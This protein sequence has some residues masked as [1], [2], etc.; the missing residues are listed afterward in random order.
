MGVIVYPDNQVIQEPNLLTP[1]RPPVGTIKINNANKYA[2]LLT[3]A[4]IFEPHK[5]KDIF[6]LKNPVQNGCVKGAHGINQ[7]GTQVI[8][9]D[10]PGF[11]LEQGS[12][13][14]TF[15]PD[16]GQATSAKLFITVDAEFQLYRVTDARVAFSINGTYR[17][18]D[19]SA[20]F[21]GGEHAMAFSWDSANTTLDGLVDSVYDSDNTA[22]YS[23]TPGS[24]NLFL[25]NRAS[26]NRNA[27]G[28]MR[29]FYMFNR[30][31]TVAERLEILADPY[32]IVMSA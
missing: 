5:D 4:A 20:V 19:F 18:L 11:S 17:Y 30:V 22:S 28:T 27:N 16:G 2:R 26:A 8:E 31:L 15:D 21:T 32:Q 23:T 10:R 29:Y 25:M 7:S 1:G 6:N 12:A 9:F 24:D 3:F 14:F 13:V